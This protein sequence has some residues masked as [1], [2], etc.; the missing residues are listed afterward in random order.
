MT[1]NTPKPEYHEL[2]RIQRDYL[3]AVARTDADANGKQLT[4][5]VESLH[6]VRPSNRTVYDTLDLL[7]DAGLVNKSNGGRGNSNR[8]D[9]TD[10]GR[11]VLESAAATIAP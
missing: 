8:Y 10:D 4:D 2:T 11:R 3:V 7:S 6:G 9:L 1:G 5:R